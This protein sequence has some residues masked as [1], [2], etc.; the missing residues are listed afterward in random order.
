M[1]IAFGHYNIGTKDG[2]NSV[3]HSNVNALLELYPKLRITL[4]G[5]IKKKLIKSKRVNYINFPELEISPE[6]RILYSQE[7]VFDYMRSGERIYQKLDYLLDKYDVVII[8]NTNLGIHPAATYGFYRFAKKNEQGLK[9]RKVLFRIHDFAEDR[10]GNFI[11]LLKFEG[12]EHSPYWH[13]IIFPLRRNLSYIVI[14]S[15]DVKKLQGHG[16]FEEN[17]VFYI[18]NPID[19]NM[20]YDDTKTSLKLRELLIK[21]EKMNKDALIMYSPVRIVPRK[22]VEE[23]IFLTMYFQYFFKKPFHLL[24]SLK[25]EFG[26]GV[27][28]AAK[29]ENFVKKHNLPVT[30]GLNEYVTLKRVKKGGKIVTFGVGDVYNICDKIISTSLLEGFGMFFIESWFFGKSIIGRDLPL[31]TPDFKVKGINLEHL[32][33]T[34]FINHKDF[35]SYD[36]KEKF[37]LILKLKSKKF[38]EAF[39]EEN[40]HSVHG[41]LRFFDKSYEKRIISNNKRHVIRHF[42]SKPIAREVMKAIHLTH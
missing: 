41:V 25:T 18:P 38:R 42:S 12:R 39:H 16:L 24:L 19:E 40:R 11:D 27:E 14:N 10:R 13:K 7:D 1:K 31:I 28:Y 32:Y 34:L 6:R 20:K 37:S 3:M 4:V 15:T 33:S 5:V 22:N 29:I 9:K 21:K 35:K 26:K 2:V 36:Q 8:E 30:V 23:A 17:K